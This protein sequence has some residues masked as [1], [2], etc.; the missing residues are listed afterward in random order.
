MSRLK[1]GETVNGVRPEQ[2]LGPTIKGSSISYTGDTVKAESVAEGSK[3]V[4]VL[5]HEST[6]MSSDSELAKE[7]FHSTAL[8]AAETAKECRASCLILTH[9]SQRYDDLNDVVAEARTVFENTLAAEDM[10]L[11]EVRGENVSLRIK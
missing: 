5:I 3:G 7:H 6:Y 1:N 9:V 8:Q 11:Y 2:V 10:Q 4:S